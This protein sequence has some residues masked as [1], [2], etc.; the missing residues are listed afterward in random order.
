MILR[1]LYYLTKISVGTERWYNV[2][3]AWSKFGHFLGSDY[4]KLLKELSSF[5]KKYRVKK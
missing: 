1:Y 3:K 2:Y 5:D 4:E